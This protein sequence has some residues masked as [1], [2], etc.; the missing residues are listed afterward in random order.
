MSDQRKMG[1]L[2]AEHAA[3]GDECPACHE[4]FAEGD[5]V[6]LVPL[7]PGPSA[8][9]RERAREGRAYNAVA[10]IVHWACATGGDAVSGRIQQ[11]EEAD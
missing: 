8:E 5:Y 2:T 7:G 11:L 1:P 3:T 4:S 10:A 9:S 6:A